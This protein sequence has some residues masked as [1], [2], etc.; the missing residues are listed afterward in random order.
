MAAYVV[1]ALIAAFS[2]L[3]LPFETRG[4]ELFEG[5]YWNPKEVVMINHQTG[6]STKML[7]VSLKMNTGLRNSEFTELAMRNWR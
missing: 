1:V 4:Y 7:S 3:M 2:C 5:Q 6:N